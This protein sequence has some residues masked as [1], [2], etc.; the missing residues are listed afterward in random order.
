M[1][2]RPSIQL[3]ITHPADVTIDPSVTK[4][5]VVDRVANDFT[6][7]AVQGFLEQSQEVDLVRF[8]VVS[9]QQ[10]YNDLAVPVNGPIPND[11]MSTLCQKSGVKGALVLHRF[12][13][14]DDLNVDKRTETRTIDGRQQTIDIYTATLRVRLT[15]RLAFPWLQWSNL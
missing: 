14:N 9:A 10:I 8:Q 13:N 12:T 2:C 5:A 3:K 11:A 15:S 1:A 4:I 7:G 6:K